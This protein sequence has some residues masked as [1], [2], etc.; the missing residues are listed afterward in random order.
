MT[1]IR[2]AAMSQKYRYFDK[3]DQVRK[4]SKYPYMKKPSPFPAISLMLLLIALLAGCA[5]TP[6]QPL[7]TPPAEDLCWPPGTDCKVRYAGEIRQF[8]QTG[9]S[10]ATL[11]TGKSQ[12]GRILKPVAIAIGPGGKMAIADQGRQGIHLYD[13]AKQS[14]QVL[15]M[16]GKEKFATPVGVAFDDAGNL[17]VTDSQLNK[18]LIFDSEAKFLKAVD[19]AD[20]SPLQRPTGI[21]FNRHDKRLYVAD[22][23]QH[24]LLVFSRLGEF[25]GRLGARG[26]QPGTFNFPTH[27]GSD[28]QGNIYITDSMNFRAQ[29][30]PAADGAWLVFGR[31]GNG[32]GDFASPKG[33]GADQNGN[34]YIAETLFDNVQIFDHSG[35]YLLAV[36]SQGSG[37]GQFW[38]PS[39]LFI[40]ENNRL[41][42]CDTYN[43]R[44]QLF[45]LLTGTAGEAAPR[46][47]ELEK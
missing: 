39:G 43:K 47:G 37:Q 26:D 31:H 6:W 15:V 16:A 25:I 28:L 36:G 20:G 29:I 13:P 24:Q 35:A 12:S 4:L 45:D 18:M 5:A 46:Q 11:I 1:E 3:I 17:Y 40:D 38:M 9:T 14:Y 44:I 41:Y 21:T 7:V 42:V 2:A 22:T 32:S 19:Q 34:I 30:L 23:M 8:A 33:I 27:L 10:L